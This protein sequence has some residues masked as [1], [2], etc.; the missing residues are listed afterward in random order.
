[1]RPRIL[2]AIVGVALLAIASLAIPLAIRLGH[3]ARDQS[4]ARLE[5]VALTTAAHLP[6]A[7]HRD[8]RLKLPDLASDGDLTVYDTAGVRLGGEGPTH[9]DAAVRRA[10]TGTTSHAQSGSALA[11]AVPLVRGLAVIAAVRASEPIGVTDDQVRRQRVTIVL[12]AAVAIIIAILTGLWLSAALA[13][14]LERLRQA[15]TRLG[16]GDFTVRAPRSGVAEADAVAEALDETAARLEGLLERERTF[17]ADAS[18]QL[19][20]PLT[21]LRLAVETELAQ[22]RP[23]PSDALHEVLTEADRLEQTIDDLLMLAR[24]TAQRSAIDPATV[25]HDANERWHA[26]FAAVGRPLRVRAPREASCE[27]HASP[28]ALGQILD[29]LLDNALRHGAGVVDL[30]LRR[31]SGG[32]GVI[33]VGNEGSG[34]ARDPEALF[35]PAARD[36]HGIGLPLAAALAEAEGARL[37]LAGPGPGVVFELTLP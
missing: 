28:A 9:A 17:S 20:T 16:H 32:G 18:H 14:P 29:V 1:M 15:A 8:S 4:M 26:R 10:L 19:R 34:I 2:A 12:A 6:N 24:G 30:T 33:A 36:T 27:A 37:R 23:D 31:G 13:R 25:I 21:S 11:V 3:D 5:R 22:P 7:L 35:A